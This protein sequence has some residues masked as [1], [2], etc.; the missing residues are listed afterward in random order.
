MWVPRPS[1]T[2]RETDVDSQT[3]ISPPTDQQHPV[4]PFGVG[5]EE[6]SFGPSLEVLNHLV[7]DPVEVVLG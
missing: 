2:G 3:D 5:R 7:D 4:N 1:I 6:Y